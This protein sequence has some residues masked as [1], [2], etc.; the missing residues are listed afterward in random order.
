MSGIQLDTCLQPVDM[1]QE[2]LDHYFDDI[3]CCAPCEG[4]SPV[5][6]LNDESNEAKCFPVL[7]PTGQPTYHDARN[8]H[9]TLGRYLHNRLMNVDNR[10]ARN[11][12]FIK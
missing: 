12:E 2:I 3:I 7:F 1:R 8:V 6:L 9:I 4:N 5:A 10:F 11:T